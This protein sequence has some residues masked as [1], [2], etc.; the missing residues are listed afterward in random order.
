MV[1]ADAAVSVHEQDPV[2]AAL[3]RA[4]L[5]DLAESEEERQAVADAKASHRMRAHGAVEAAITPR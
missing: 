5:D 1:H 2:L 3:M 4:P